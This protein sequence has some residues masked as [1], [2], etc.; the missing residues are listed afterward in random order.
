MIQARL[1][2]IIILMPFNIKHIYVKATNFNVFLWDL[3]K[4]T[5]AKRKN[6]KPQ[7]NDRNNFNYS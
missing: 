2:C 7:Y 4:Y 3:L 6:A 5:T 1:L